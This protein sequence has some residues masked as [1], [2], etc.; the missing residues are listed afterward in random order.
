M[1]KAPLEAAFTTRR[2]DDRAAPHPG[3]HP[4]LL[5]RVAGV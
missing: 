2:I 5:W 3:R 1:H 4:E